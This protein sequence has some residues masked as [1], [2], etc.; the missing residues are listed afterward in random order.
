MRPEKLKEST[1]NR[2]C[3]IV[4]LFHFFS[5]LCGFLSSANK[6]GAP[7]HAMQRPGTLLLEFLWLGITSVRVQ[8][9]ALLIAANVKVLGYIWLS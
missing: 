8:T 3:V 1:T 4:L 6:C 2:K 9:T 5:S 7:W